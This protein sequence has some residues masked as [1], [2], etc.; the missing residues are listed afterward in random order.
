M[1]DLWLFGGHVRS[2]NPTFDVRTADEGL[3]PLWELE[4]VLGDIPGSC[5]EPFLVC[6]TRLCKG[7]FSFRCGEAGLPG[8]SNR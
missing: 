4:S 5:R 1:V 8:D 6:E 3:D 2:L 7:E